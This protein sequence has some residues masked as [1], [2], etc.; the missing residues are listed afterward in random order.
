MKKKLNYRVAAINPKIKLEG[1]SLWAARLVERKRENHLDQNT[2]ADKQQASAAVEGEEGQLSSGE[3]DE[4]DDDEED[5]LKDRGATSCSSGR[6]SVKSS[7]RTR[8][9]PQLSDD[10]TDEELSSSAELS[11]SSDV[12][13]GGRRRHFVPSA[14]PPRPAHA[15]RATATEGRCSLLGLGIVFH[16]QNSLF[17]LSKGAKLFFIIVG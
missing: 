10:E 12:G 8:H 9:A 11:S 1:T 5:T 3:L 14:P 17:F 2:G 7:G 4:E 15:T 6:R 13:R 16:A